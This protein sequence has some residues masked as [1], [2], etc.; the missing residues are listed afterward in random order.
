MGR[1]QSAP[2]GTCKLCLQTRVLQDSHLM[3]KALY[4]LSRW[5]G[6]PNPNP[7]MLTERG[8]VQTSKQVKDYVFCRE[9]EQRFS[10]GGEHYALGQVRLKG[11]F[12]L[13]HT[14]QSSNQRTSG[15][16]TFHY[17]VSTLGIDK[18]KL[19]YF[20]LSVFWRASV[21]IWHHDKSTP[22]IQL[23]KYEEQIR[24]YL[25]RTSPFPASVA[26][27]L[28]VCT[29]PYSQN[30][31]YEPSLGM[32][33]PMGW[34]FQARGL[35]FYLNEADGAPLPLDATKACLIKGTK[36]MVVSLSCAEKVLGAAARLINIANQ[37]RNR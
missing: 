17:D 16:F 33:N 7:M 13:L 4:R 12:P 29:D 26:L 3:P 18:E 23:G 1:K 15:G 35:N 10:R 31:F 8:R 14:L 2:A 21:H 34:S 24:T 36:D 19:A 9:C 22:L 25:L 5:E 20:A 37:N 30:T 32:S 6:M 11:R 28:F 27:L